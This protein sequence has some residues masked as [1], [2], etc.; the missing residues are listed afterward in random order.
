MA[1]HQHVPRPS[2][3]AGK[4]VRTLLSLSVGVAVGLAPYLGMTGVPMF[5][6]LLD[7]IPLTLRDSTIPVSAALMGIIA[8]AVQWFGAERLS[9]RTLRIAFVLTL[10]LAILGLFGFMWVH[11]QYV[12][13][14]RADGGRRAA[15]FVVG[16]VRLPTCGCP[17]NV[18]DQQCINGL[19]WSEAAIAGC[20][21]DAAIRQ[22][23]LKIQ[24]LYLITTGTF[25][26]LVSLITLR[27]TIR[28]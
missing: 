21:G 10:I 8:A 6:P 15:S 23:Q 28:S 5:R 16:T 11:A 3:V 20:W 14:V 22:A 4:W 7:L 18:S 25:G 9:R 19:S 24:T 13:N 26:A 27:G 2:G 12:V 1:A 17:P